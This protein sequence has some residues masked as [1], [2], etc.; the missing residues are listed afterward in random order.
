MAWRFKVIGVRQ[1]SLTRSICIPWWIRLGVSRLFIQCL[2]RGFVVASQSKMSV[3]GGSVHV[4]FQHRT[5]IAA[6]DDMVAGMQRIIVARVGCFSFAID[7][8]R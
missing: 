6:G 7:H 5:P 8:Q 4:A 3:R 2:D 1:L